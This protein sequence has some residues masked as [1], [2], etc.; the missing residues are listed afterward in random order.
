MGEDPDRI[1]RQIEATRQELRKTVDAPAP[2]AR[3]ASRR[4]AVRPIDHVRGEINGEFRSAREI[5]E[6]LGM[7][8]QVVGPP[9][10]MLRRHGEVELIHG[11][12]GECLW[13]ET[14]AG[15]LHGA[16][17]TERAGAVGEDR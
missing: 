10:G 4:I 9:L 13:R 15:G 1:R 11:S 12:S 7:A 6:R 2:G 5:A 16:R 17:S 14:S 3:S 8:V